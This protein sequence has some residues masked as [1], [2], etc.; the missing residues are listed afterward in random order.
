MIPHNVLCISIEGDSH[1]NQDFKGPTQSFWME[2][3][4]AMKVAQ[5]FRKFQEIQ[6]HKISTHSLHLNVNLK[7][8]FQ[9][10]YRVSTNAL[11]SLFNAYLARIWIVRPLFYMFFACTGRGWVLF[12]NLMIMFSWGMSHRISSL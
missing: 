9:V 5:V 1:L 6:F 12:L 10:M 2:C 11:L 3:F 7:N 8:S 4:K